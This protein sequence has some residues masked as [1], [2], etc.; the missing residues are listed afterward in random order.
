VLVS[1]KAYT[2]VASGC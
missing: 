2:V 1:A